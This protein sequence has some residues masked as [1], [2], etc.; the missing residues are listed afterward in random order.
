MEVLSTL[1][2][3]WALLL[4]QIIN[5]GIILF[6]L[7]KFVYR[8]V[9]NLIDKRRQ[10][11]EQSMRD[12]EAIEVQ[13]RDAEK[14]RKE[15]LARADQEAGL[16]LERAKADADQV[17]KEIVTAAEREV[18]N[19]RQRGKKELEDE[20]ARVYGEVQEQMTKAAL[21][22]TEKILQREFSPADQKRLLTTLEKEL[23]AL[24]S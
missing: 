14:A 1:G 3:D 20:R 12:V 18:D 4:A 24:L 23:P 15:R 5:F 2:I 22:M 13:K 7:T 11:V 16:I 19:L 10:L 9:L 21:A 6:I 8:P 17:K